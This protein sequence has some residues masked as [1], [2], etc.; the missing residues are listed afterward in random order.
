MPV[1]HPAQQLSTF[2][3]KR[4]FSNYWSNKRKEFKGKI[5]YDL[6]FF[7]QIFI[8]LKREH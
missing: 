1:Y 4:F 8:V 6:K 5:G 3:Q 7:F 2:H